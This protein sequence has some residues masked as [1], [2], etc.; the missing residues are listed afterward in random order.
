[1]FKL[2]PVLIV[3]IAVIGIATGVI[4][5]QINNEKLSQLPTAALELTKNQGVASNVSYYF[6]M[7][8]RKAELALAGSSEK[9]FELNMK[10]VAADTEK[11]KAALDANTNPPDIIMKTKL[12]NESLERAKKGAEEISDEAI[13]KLRDEWVKLLAAA[14]RELSRLSSLA[15]E[16]KKFQEEL[17][18]LAPAPQGGGPTPTATPTPVPLKF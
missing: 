5:I 1:M 15:D 3:V 16:Y 9:K 13:G 11:L 6:T 18:N 8:K 10:Y 7:Y 2:I 17:S 14:D 4:T 12:L